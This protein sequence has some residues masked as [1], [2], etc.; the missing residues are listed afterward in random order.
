MDE[1]LKGL[2]FVMVYIDDILIASRSPEEHKKH[3]RAVLE[4]LIDNALQ[5]NVKKCVFGEEEVTFLGHVINSRGI[6][7]IPEKVQAIKN[8]TKPKTFTELRRFLGMV[9]FYR[10]NLKNAATTQ[11]P[12][13]KF[14][15][16][17]KKN[18]KTPIL[19]NPEAE[20]AF[21]KVK[22]DLAQATLLVHP[23]P[24]AKIRLISD[25]SDA[26][27]GAALEQQVLDGPWEPLAFF[28]RKFSAKQLR[29]STY[30]RELIAIF[31]SIKYFRHILEACEF[32]FHT[33][34]KP[35][36]YAFK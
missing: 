9:N 11:A 30:N 3:L 35:I 28:S 32:E 2:D 31:E 33:D 19:W 22:E 15:I 26:A 36:I 27:M 13:N 34:H 20:A 8:F 7:P 6:S 1:V 24:Q 21:E 4:R 23:A 18:D 17:S 10:R 16:N 25:A 12:L 5:I 29:Y 14:L